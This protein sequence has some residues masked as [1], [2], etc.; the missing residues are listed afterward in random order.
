MAEIKKYLDTAALTTLVE[1]I[2]KADVATLNSSK[3][4]ADGLAKNYDSA[5]SAATAESNAKAYTDALA[6]GQVATN[7]SDIET[8]KGTGEG[9]VAKAVADA[10][11]LVDA[12]VDAVESI[13]NKNKEDIAAINNAESGILAQAKAYADTEVAEVQGNVDTLSGYVGTFTHDTA[14]T[15]VEYINA[16]TDGIATSGNLEALGS[17]V[18]AVEGKVA[19][20][21]GDYLKSADKTALE[22]QISAKADQTALDEVSGVANAAATKV[23]LE[24]EVNRAKGEEARIEGLVTAE[25]AK[26][27]EEEGKLDAR[28]VE[29]E[30]FFKTAEGETLD[31]ALDTLVEIQ[32]YITSEGA[33]AD[34]MVLDIAANKKSIEDHIATDHDFAGADAALKSELEGQINAKADSSVVT[35]LSGKV[36]TNEQAIEALQGVDT[37]LSGRIDV[38]EGQLGESGSVAEDIEAAKQEAISTAAGDAT[39]KAN[40]AESNAK[41]YADGLNTAMDARVAVVEGKAHE[42]TN[43][44][45]LDLIVSGDKAKWDAA[46]AKAHEHANSAELAK[47]VDGDVAKWNAAEGNAKTYADGLNTAMTTKV[48]GIGGRV[49]TLETTIV[50]KAEQDDL[51][52]LTTRVSTAEG[53]IITLTSA[54]NSFTP[55]TSSEVTAL[56]A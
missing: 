29:V 27:R 53:N 5:G 26:A 28:L 9:S 15:V 18:T 21:E 40:T 34:Q 33:A 25:A 46:A 20:I 1:E 10:K 48:D 52:A 7:K 19:T 44:S 37:T 49:S 6:N 11:A 4:Y 8:L 17:R 42:H 35:E 39:S 14:K 47:I 16:K 30:T 55:I 54:I 22:G 38:L 36:S 12:D 3:S 13:A 51:E 2:K 43:K 45:E 24:E 41:G 56:F 50:D 31:Q 23:A 32:G